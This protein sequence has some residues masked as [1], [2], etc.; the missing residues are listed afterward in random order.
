MNCREDWFSDDDLTDAFLLESEALEPSWEHQQDLRDRLRQAVSQRTRFAGQPTPSELPSSGISRRW[1][2]FGEIGDGDRGQ[3][4]V[5][6]H[7]MDSPGGYRYGL[8]GAAWWMATLVV[9]LLLVGLWRPTLNGATTDLTSAL[10]SMRRQAWI[11]STTVIHQ[12]GNRQEF[13]AWL[14]PGLGTAAIRSSDHFHHI[15]YRSRIQTRYDRRT[16]EV[17]R[18]RVDSQAEPFHREFVEALLRDGDLQASMPRHRVSP[19]RKRSVE[20]SGE[21][22]IQYEFEIADRDF[23]TMNWRAVVLASE[24]DKR[25]HEW[26]EWHADGKRIE[27]RFDY[28]DY[29]PM[30]V[31]EMGGKADATV[32]DRVADENIVELA[33]WSRQRL[34][35]FGDYEGIVWE[36]LVGRLADAQGNFKQGDG[37]LLRVWRSGRAFGI[38]CF[39]GTCSESEW[40]TLRAK[41]IA[42]IKQGRTSVSLIECDGILCRIHPA[43]FEYRGEVRRERIVQ[44]ESSDLE[45]AKPDSVC[46]PV[47]TLGQPNGAHTTIPLWTD[48]FPEYACRPFLWTTHPKFRFEQTRLDSGDFSE[49]NAQV[50]GGQRVATRIQVFMGEPDDEEWLSTFDLSPAHQGCLNESRVRVGQ[51]HMAFGSISGMESVT[52]LYDEYL[53]SPQGGIYATKHRILNQQGDTQRIRE[54]KLAFETGPHAIAIPTET[55]RGD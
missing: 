15:D 31:F 54:F 53:T 18:W 6:S 17:Y 25:I 43:A 16:D 11:H 33:R 50:S 40:R 24:Q 42:E 21:S 12:D 32:H 23:P 35:Q 45:Q 37:R 47:A 28:P 29:G 38:E 4:Q 19:V 22:W 2:H 46:V 27:T 51:G 44:D 13:E 48:L 55:L 1:T 9:L 39:D 41:P 26:F 30:D 7:S 8:R 20:R 5:R 49:G 36:C 34:I 3:S 14:S 10:D 52:T